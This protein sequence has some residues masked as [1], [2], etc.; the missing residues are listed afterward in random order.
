M[1]IN[2]PTKFKSWRILINSIWIATNWSIRLRYWMIK[3]LVQQ[4]VPMDIVTNLNQELGM[5]YLIKLFLLNYRAK[6]S[7]QISNT[8]SKKVRILKS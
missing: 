8:Q 1:A 2:C 4:G 3:K 7:S 6:G 5:S